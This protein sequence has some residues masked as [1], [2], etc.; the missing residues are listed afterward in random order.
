MFARCTACGWPAFVVSDEEATDEVAMWNAYAESHDN[1]NR[2]QMDSFSRCHR[3]GAG[4]FVKAEL[5]QREQGVTLQ[6]VV[7]SLVN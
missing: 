2:V 7:A 4:N 1:P 6:P 5:T 3:C